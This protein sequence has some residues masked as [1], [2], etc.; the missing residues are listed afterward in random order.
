MTKDCFSWVKTASRISESPEYKALVVAFALAEAI[1][2]NPNVI[3]VTAIGASN[4]TAMKSVIATPTAKDT[5]IKL[6][7]TV[8][9]NMRFRHFFGASKTADI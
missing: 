4:R 1:P 9:R 8:K 2:T 5:P 7:V 6:P 3:P